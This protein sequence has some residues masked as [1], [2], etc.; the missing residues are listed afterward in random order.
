MSAVASFA[1]ARAKAAKARDALH[2][3][4]AALDVAAQNWARDAVVAYSKAHPRRLVTFCAAMGTTTLSVERGGN[5]HTIDFTTREP[6]RFYNGQAIPP[7]PFMQAMWDAA[8]EQD[9]C[10]VGSSLLLQCKGGEII[11]D[12]T[13]W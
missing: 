2:E 11:R 7:P 5:R 12:T 8:E 10:N 4:Q 1:A 13:D 9:L 3:A 6:T